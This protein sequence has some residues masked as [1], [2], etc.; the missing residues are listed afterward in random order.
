M[1]A[2]ARNLVL[3][4]FQAVTL[5]RGA[6]RLQVLAAEGDVIQGRGV[7]RA[8]RTI[9]GFRLRAIDQ[10]YDRNAAEIEPI[11]LEG[12]SRPFAHG[13]SKHVAIEIARAFQAG[14]AD[15]VVLEHFDGHGLTTPEALHHRLR[16]S[17]EKRQPREMHMILD[18]DTDSR[19]DHGDGL[20]LRRTWPA[21]LV[22][23]RDR[24]GSR[25]RIGGDASCRREIFSP[26][27]RCCRQ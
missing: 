8:M 2:P 22:P 5:E 4:E 26:R 27:A 3:A 21:D 9:A 16:T 25:R 24:G 6:G 13:K 19:G 15:R 23:H 17:P 10:V 14:A 1:D 18:V 11:A 20:Y 12:K 7:A